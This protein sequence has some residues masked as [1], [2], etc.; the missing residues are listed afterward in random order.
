MHQY[1]PMVFILSWDDSSVPLPLVCCSD[2]FSFGHCES[3][4]SWTDAPF[5]WLC[6]CGLVLSTCS[7]PGTIR[8]SRL[9]SHI[10]CPRPRINYFSAEIFS[11]YLWANSARATVWALVGLAKKSGHLRWENEVPVCV[12]TKDFI[13]VQS[14]ST[15]HSMISPKATFFFCCRNRILT[16]LSSGEISHESQIYGFE[17]MSFA[18]YKH[19]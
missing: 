10:S 8:W 5:T 19:K 17:N 11:S 4:F 7:C 3:S 13:L 18:S 16:N 1:W 9:I 6:H 12:C 15:H 2:H 14:L